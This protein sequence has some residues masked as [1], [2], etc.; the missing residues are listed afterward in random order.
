MQMSEFDQSRNYLLKAGKLSPGNAEIR[1][2]LEKLN[3]YV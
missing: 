2:E 3:R 1:Q